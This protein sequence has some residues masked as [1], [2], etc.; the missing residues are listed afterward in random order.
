MIRFRNPFKKWWLL[1]HVGDPSMAW[2]PARLT[3]VF[4]V[5]LCFY[6]FRAKGPFKSFDDAL[7]GARQL[8]NGG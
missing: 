6:V 2:Y 1:Q 3:T 5:P 4:G 7:A 8:A